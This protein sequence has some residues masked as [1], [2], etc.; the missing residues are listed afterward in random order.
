MTSRL[1]S[2]S[3]AGVQI[4][5]CALSA[6]GHLGWYL[7]VGNQDCSK[8]SNQ[9]QIRPACQ[10]RT[11]GGALTSGATL[12]NSHLELFNEGFS[13]SSVPSLAAGSEWKLSSAPSFLREGGGVFGG[14]R[15]D[16][17]PYPD[18]PFR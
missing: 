4:I 1:A 2:L 17:R 12:P 14:G 5:S 6:Q 10:S 18:Q 15:F 9:F 13:Q 16:G 3:V 7:Q 8:S 11:A